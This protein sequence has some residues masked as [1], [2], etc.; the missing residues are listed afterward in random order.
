MSEHFPECPLKVHNN[1][2]E[3]YNPKVCAI[4]RKE[5]VCLWKHPESKKESADFKEVVKRIKEG[6]RE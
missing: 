6:R 3:F 1:C 5:K 4:A 2:K